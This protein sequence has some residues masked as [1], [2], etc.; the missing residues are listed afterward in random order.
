[1]GL[2]KE[3]KNVDMSMESKPW[4]EEELKEFRALMQ[5]IKA[6]NISKL[7]PIK[8]TATQSKRKLETT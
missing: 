8:P 3:S 1:M 4:T 2:I 7:K 6:K 5:K